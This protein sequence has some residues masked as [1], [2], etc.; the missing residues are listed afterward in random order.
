MN[1]F[2]EVFQG[3][4][5]DGVC[6][7]RDY[8]FVAGLQLLLRFIMLGAFSTSL[9]KDIVFTC[10]LI[11]LILWTVG[12]LML[13]PYKREL[14][15]VFEAVLGTYNAILIAAM[16][17]LY[18]TSE[19]KGSLHFLFILGFFLVAPGVLYLL[20]AILRFFKL[21]RCHLRVRQLLLK[22]FARRYYRPMENSPHPSL[23]LPRKFEGLLHS[24]RIGMVEYD[25]HQSAD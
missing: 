15:N 2:L 17:Q 16:A 20:L 8:R 21:C 23:S 12:G 10:T 24:R 22:L 4:F 25:D 9:G 13:R 1:A 19:L 14:Y 7:R 3:H 11:G 18:Y 6:H 5:K